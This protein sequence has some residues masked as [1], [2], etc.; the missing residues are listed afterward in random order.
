MGIIFAL[1][2]RQV[3]LH[4]ALNVVKKIILEF[5]PMF[6]RHYVLLIMLLPD[7]E[8]MPILKISN[9]LSANFGAKS[10]I[11]KYGQN[12]SEISHPRYFSFFL[13]NPFIS[14]KQKFDKTS[15]I[16]ELLF[17]TSA[18]CLPSPDSA[19]KNVLMDNPSHKDPW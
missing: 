2:F 12:W 7:I 16:F 10:N 6:K 9:Y 19:Q 18:P 15:Q 3:L 17:D 8:N 11:V 1:N 4:G 5:M 14:F 13:D